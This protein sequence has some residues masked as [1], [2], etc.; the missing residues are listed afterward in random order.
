MIYEVFLV[1]CSAIV[2]A[3][4]TELHCRLQMKQIAKS[5][6]A[7]NLFIHYLIAVGCFIVTLGSAQVLFHAYSLA[8]IPNMQRMIFL[9][10]SSLVFVMPIVFITGWRYPNILAKMEKWRDSEKS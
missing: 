1:I 8:D 3:L 9:V 2:C 5:K 10:I 7:K 4:A 6:T